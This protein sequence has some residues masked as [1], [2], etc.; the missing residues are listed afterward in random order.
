VRLPPAVLAALVAVILAVQGL[1]ALDPPTLILGAIDWTGHFATVALLL[2][3]SP[4]RL[5]PALIA[6][7]FAATLIDLDHIP[8]IVGD[9]DLSNTTPRPVSH[10]LVTVLAAGAIAAVLRARLRD[11]RYRD[12]ALGVAIGVPLHLLRDV[13]TG[14]GV[15]LFWPLSAEP[16]NGMFLVYLVAMIAV[17]A[18]AATRTRRAG[19]PA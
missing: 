8:D 11:Q 1:L 18:Y 9:V 12:F 7:A 19:R 3:A 4:K 16:V 2:A 6:G 14:P 17:A 5:P 15:A 10:S 13:F